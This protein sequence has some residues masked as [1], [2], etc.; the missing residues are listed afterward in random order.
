VHALARLTEVAPVEP[1]R[2]DP[3]VVHQR[4]RGDPMIAKHVD[5]ETRNRRLEPPAVVPLSQEEA[6]VLLGVKKAA[7]LQAERA[8][9]AAIARYTCRGEPLTSTRTRADFAHTTSRDTLPHDRL[10]VHV[11]KKDNVPGPGSYEV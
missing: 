5:R 10:A 6:T 11:T 2:L 8:D 4:T 9:P 7:A 3:P 1:E